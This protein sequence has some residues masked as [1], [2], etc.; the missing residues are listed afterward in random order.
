MQALMSS[1]IQGQTHS[2]R[3]T[4]ADGRGGAHLSS[5]S[6]TTVA[7]V[8]AILRARSS[9]LPSV[10]LASMLALL[11][12]LCTLLCL[13]LTGYA[14]TTVPDVQEAT[15]ACVMDDQG[16]ILYDLNAEEEMAMASITKIMTAMVALDSGIPLDTPIPF[17]ETDFVS[18]AQLAGYK[19]GD[20][21]SFRELL[22]ATLIFS[23]NDAAINVA[24][25][26]SGDEATFA[27]LMNQKAQELGLTHTHFMNSHGIEEEGHYS[28]ARDLVV[29]GRYAMEHYP[30]IAQCVQTHSIDVVA[31]GAS[32][33]LESTDSLMGSY[34]GLLGIKTGRT[35]SGMSFLGAARRN[36]VTL[37][38]C[39]LC[40]PTYEGRFDDTVAMLDWG[41]D[42]YEARRLASANAMLR[43]VAWQDGFW[44]RCPVAAER[45]ITGQVF[46]E[47][48]LTYKAVQLK[49]NSLVRAESTYGTTVWQQE[50][51]HVESATY[52]AASPQARCHAWN[53]FVAPLFSQS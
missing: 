44:L 46:C 10:L 50:G 36:H 25:A 2:M 1:R 45:D 43:T 18:D 39:A 23:G 53:P 40:C 35:T 52:V 26:V 51:R 20:T 3:L 31:G 14:L 4:G 24:F 34:E 21:P 32:V 41:F 28:C 29:M 16:N 42:L 38:S 33:T 17:I 5:M 11:L 7:Q 19:N 8:G 27:G 15:A 12:A 47:G 6:E 30:F 22:Q 49:P 9:H 48:Q 37:Y 13:P